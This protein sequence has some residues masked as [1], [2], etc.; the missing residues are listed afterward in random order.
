[1]KKLK[2]RKFLIKTYQVFIKT[3]TISTLI[4]MIDGTK[5]GHPTIIVQLSEP[6][7]KAIATKPKAGQIDPQT[8]NFE[9]SPIYP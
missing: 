4:R 2:T 9:S 1:M 3:I 6:I 7:D 5:P 8:S